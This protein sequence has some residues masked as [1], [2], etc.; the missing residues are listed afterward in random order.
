MKEGAVALAE[1]P[2]SDGSLK[3]RPVI[4]LRKL[5]PYGDWLL[6]GVSTQLH[7]RVPGFDDLIEQ[8]APDYAISG[9]KASSIIRLGF[10]A[11]LPAARLVGA[12]GRIADGRHRRLLNTLARHLSS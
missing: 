2:Q 4:L 7:Q 3:A 8:S 6:C 5:P 9:L 10:L 1:L 11:V 12:I